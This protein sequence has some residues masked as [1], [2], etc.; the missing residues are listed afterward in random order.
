MTDER[1]DITAQIHEA[2][3]AYL[4]GHWTRFDGVLNDLKALAVPHLLSVLG[5]G[6]NGK[7]SPLAHAIASIMGPPTVDNFDDAPTPAAPP[8]P[9]PAFVPS[10]A[11]QSCLRGVHAWL[12][13]APITGWRVCSACGYTN[14]APPEGNGP[15]DVGQGR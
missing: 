10:G 3:D 12:P 9:E 13:P 2:V 7:A 14:V 4:Q 8:P 11:T 6:D 5:D 15:V 1:P